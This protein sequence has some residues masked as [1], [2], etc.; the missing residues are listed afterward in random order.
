MEKIFFKVDG[1]NLFGTI[2]YPSKL[3]D[4]NPGKNTSSSDGHWI[5]NDDGNHVFVKNK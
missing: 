1:D 2:L 5:T 4:K 3:K